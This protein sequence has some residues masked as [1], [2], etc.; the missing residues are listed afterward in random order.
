MKL[1]LLY[2]MALTLVFSAA[3]LTQKHLFVNTNPDPDSEDHFASLV[4]AFDWIG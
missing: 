2:L 4:E 3:S 1:V